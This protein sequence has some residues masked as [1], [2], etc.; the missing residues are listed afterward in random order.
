[1]IFNYDK[2]EKILGK[3]AKGARKYLKT[4]PVWCKKVS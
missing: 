3:N 2:I 1:M 4:P